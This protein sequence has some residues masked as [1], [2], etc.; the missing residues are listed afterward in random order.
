MSKKKSKAA[1][2]ISKEMAAQLAELTNTITG[3]THAIGTTHHEEDSRC[4]KWAERTNKYLEKF[5]ATRHN[6]LPNCD[7]DEKD[8]GCGEGTGDTTGAVVDLIVLID[9]SGSM[10]ESASAVSNAAGKAIKFAEVTCPND[11]RVTYFGVDGIW[12]TT[13]FI[14]SHRDYIYALHGSATPLAADTNHV[15]LASEQGANAIEDLSSLFDWR[16]GACR[17]I[18]Y[19]SDEELDSI[20]PTG[21]YANENTV[22]DAA[23]AAANANNV[24]VFA[25]H[26]TYQN[27]GA[28]IEQNY[29]DLCQMTGGMVHFSNAPDEGEYIKLLQEAI[30]NA[31][32]VSTC[33]EIDFPKIKPCISVKWGD[34]DCDCIESSDYEV[35]TL[36]V[37]NCYANLTMSNFTIARIAVLD[38]AGHPAALLPNGKPS[39]A[40][41]PIG[42]FCFG[43]IAPCSCVSREF[44]IINEGAKPGKYQLRIAGVCFDVTQTIGYST[45]FELDICMD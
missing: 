26:L 30:C 29:T 19:I 15:G 31:C 13:A 28:Q 41:H 17:A 38:E 25:H 12:P 44:V 6:T 42:V 7:P 21:D 2:V 20:S 11:L 1:A 36:T 39:V 3:T 34:S 40:V 33:T 23:I 4:E 5:D 37:C 8:C 32:G 9:T 45:C 24:T 22:T 16:D 27:R 18:F 35:M 43:D 10:S 14:Q